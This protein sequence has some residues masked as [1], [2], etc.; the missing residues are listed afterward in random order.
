MSARSQ[1]LNTKGPLLLN[2]S[3]YAAVSKVQFPE[4]GPGRRGLKCIPEPTVLDMEVE[5][6]IACS[7]QH[8]A[9]LSKLMREN[10]PAHMCHNVSSEASTL[11][12]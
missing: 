1:V 7:L 12:R 11:T 10:E 4:E 3:L 2:L 5:D 8:V 9:C 6:V